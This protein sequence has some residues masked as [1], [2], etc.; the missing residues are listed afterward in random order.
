MI[1]T[2]A[3]TE[4]SAPIAS[5]VVW[6]LTARQLHDAY[7]RSR[8]VE[9]VRRG[10]GLFHRPSAELY[11]LLE[12]QQMS[13]FELGEL[14]ERLIWHNAIVM[15][16]RLLDEGRRHY[17]ERVVT[18]DQGLVRSIERR[19]R[20]ATLPMNW[21]IITTKRRIAQYWAHASTRRIGWDRARRSVPWS[22]VN[23]W[24]CEGQVFDESYLDEQK[25]LL[26]KLVGRWSDPGQ[27]IEGIASTDK[28]IWHLENE[29]PP[30]GNKLIGP[31]W[32]GSG[33]ESTNERCVVGPS[34]KADRNKEP[35]QTIV[36]TISDVPMSKASSTS[37]QRKRSGTLYRT[38]KRLID[39]LFSAAV[40]VCLSP[41]LMAIAVVILVTDG[42]PIFYG[43][44]R[45]GRGGKSFRCWKFRTMRKDAD[46]MV[47][48]LQSDNVC[49]GP[50]VLIQNDPRV[51]KIGSILRRTQIDELPQFFNVLLGQ[52]SI[53]GPRPSP[54][55]EN[56]LCPAW[57]DVRLSVRPGIT[58][59][60]QLK[61]TRQPGEDFQEWI[62]FDIE[63][64]RTASMR[65]DMSILIETIWSFLNGSLRRGND[66]K[67]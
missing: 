46:S 50:Q 35:L 3:E 17:S 18:D 42:R 55:G 38:G 4:A 33:C 9:C 64:V 45:Q 65:T 32:L 28:D 40:L 56:Q 48:S 25:S 60:W 22:R 1:G 57:R 19:Y 31:L 29:K 37:V 34:W 47:S 63:Y 62:R 66:T 12:E 24:K 14:S 23:H 20:D 61:R 54:D 5:P 8:G 49:D 52:M 30:R 41:L 53:V 51:T 13:L 58:G 67:S 44:K 11:L 6:G 43:H 59:L 16:L 39:I 27:V 7:W 26:T 21:V 15:R 36:R 2:L 10:A